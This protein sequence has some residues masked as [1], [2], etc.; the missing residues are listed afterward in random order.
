MFRVIILLFISLTL[1]GN[2]KATEESLP[3]GGKF[4]L[5]VTDLHDID[6]S[7]HEYKAE[8]YSWF[9][10]DKPDYNLL[11]KIEITN[12]KEFSIRNAKSETIDGKHLHSQVFQGTIKQNWDV[13]NYPF[14]TQELLISLTAPINGV[15]H[16]LD[17]TSNIDDMIIPEGWSLESFDVT[18]SMKNYPAMFGDAN[19]SDG[20]N[21]QF[22]EAQVVITLK[23]S[24]LRTFITSFLGLF[25]ATFLIITV[26]FV[27]SSVR[28]LAI[29]PLQPRITLCSGSLFAA[30]GAIYGLD[31]NI[32]FGTNF[33]LSDSLEITTFAGI[34]FAV[35]SSIASDILIKTDK[36]V[37]HRNLMASLWTLFL[38]SHFGFNGYL[39]ST[40]F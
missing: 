7:N 24:G 38:F 37:F 26:L 23:R 5:V 2:V 9:L 28:R 17:K 30:V 1:I 27:N 19:A 18:H 8:F 31:A 16:S 3:S 11:E 12:A 21:H 6:F 39:I 20:N 4:G 13:S 35:L 15:A 25:V 32:P 40:S 14:D 29:I 36:V 10:T 22:S 33:T 34:G